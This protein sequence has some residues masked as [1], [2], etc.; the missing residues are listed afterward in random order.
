MFVGPRQ[1]E[2]REYEERA[3]GSR[4][5]LVRNRYSSISHGTERSHYRG[6]AIWHRK[7]VEADGFVTDGFNMSH[8]FTYGYEDVAEVV[9]IGP[10]VK[11]VQIG[12]MVACSAHHRESRIYHLDNP[13]SGATGMG[14]VAVTL[15]LPALPKDENMDKYVFISLGTVALDAV[16]LGV[17]RLGESVVVIGQGV[18][19]LL[20]KCASFLAPIR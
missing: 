17:P 6:E 4:E 1:V 20:T 10:N 9:S 5:I 3:P 12:D 14:G 7:R 16:L 11:E 18:V 19:G 13:S 2:V 8:P 15:S